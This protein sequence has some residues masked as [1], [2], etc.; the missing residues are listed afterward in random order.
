MNTRAYINIGSNLGDRRRNLW[1]GV[2]ALLPLATDGRI[3]CSDIIESEPAG[4]ASPNRFLNI[5]VAMNIGCTPHQLLRFT[6]DVERQLHATP[7]RDASGSYIDRTLDIDII[8]VDDIRIDTPELTLPH[9]RMRQ[10]EF[11]MI[12]LRQLGYPCGG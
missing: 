6:Q 5:G 12:P 4:F 2:L 1:R 9:P 10:R 8:A 7:H 3:D 11:V